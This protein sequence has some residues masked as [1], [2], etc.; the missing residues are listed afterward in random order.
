M[1]SAFS[2]SSVPVMTPPRGSCRRASNFC[3]SVSWIAVPGRP[4]PG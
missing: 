1:A 2:S 4:A 3:P